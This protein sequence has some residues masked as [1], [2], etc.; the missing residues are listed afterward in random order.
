MDG[1]RA[2][3]L[4]RKGEAMR[5][6][7]EGAAMVLAGDLRSTFGAV[8]DALMNGVRMFGTLVHNTQQ[9]EPARGQQILSPAFEGLSAVF[10]GR[11]DIVEAVKRMNAV[12]R[13][14]NLAVVDLGCA[15]PLE[16]FTQARAPAPFAPQAAE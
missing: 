11:A 12:V 8:D 15:N 16:T 6:F 4:A 2:A 13:D 10:K 1:N 7:N 14:S 5:T 9:L 3:P